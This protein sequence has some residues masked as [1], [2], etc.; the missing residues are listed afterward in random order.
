MRFNLTLCNLRGVSCQQKLP[1]IFNSF[2]GEAP[3]DFQLIW[4]GKPVSC[5]I[6]KNTLVLYRHYFVQ[7]NLQFASLFSV[8]DS[9]T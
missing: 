1:K 9:H 5:L 7:S 4:P 6:P 2:D 3:T 8:N